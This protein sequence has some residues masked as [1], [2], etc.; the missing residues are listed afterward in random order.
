MR[1]EKLFGLL[2]TLILVAGTSTALA[3]K[4]LTEAEVDSLV[5]NTSDSQHVIKV[6]QDR[7]LAF[8]V[9]RPYLEKL[10][11]KGVKEKVIAALCVAASGPLSKDQLIVLLKSGMPDK[12]LAS[13]VKRRHLTFMPSEDDL[14]QFRGLGAGDQ[15]E[16]ALQNPK[17]VIATVTNGNHKANLSHAA[18]A[19][20]IQLAG[21][22]EVTPPLLVYRPIPHYTRA[23]RQARISGV[24]YLSIV[25]ND[26]G[27]VTD[28]K[29][30]RGLGY[31]LDENALRSVKLWK[32]KPARRNGQPFT[33]RVTV[34]V[35][36]ALDAEHLP[37]V[38]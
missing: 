33:V 27:D 1:R 36:F 31:G 25:I 21:G 26:K 22:G 29:V 28:A 13:L 2:L 4:P 12:S 11:L 16:F 34:E 9:S 23:A 8:T 30:T 7:G 19:G 10:K 6:I 17:V 3:Q 24:V 20:A 5:T 32:F 38:R 35:D 18:Q 15:L 37:G 14:D